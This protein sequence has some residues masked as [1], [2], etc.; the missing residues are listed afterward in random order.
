MPP[1]P[2]TQASTTD[3]IVAAALAAKTELDHVVSEAAKTV[4][5]AERKFWQRIGELSKSR[6]GAQ[7]DIAAAL[8]VERDNIYKNV[9]KHTEA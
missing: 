1:R 4:S 5:E 7:K 8:N 6:R 3:E 9:R 2:D